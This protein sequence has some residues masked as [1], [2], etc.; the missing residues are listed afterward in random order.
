MALVGLEEG[1]EVKIK[2]PAGVKRFEVLSLLT[3]HQQ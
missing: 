1:A 2:I 3:V